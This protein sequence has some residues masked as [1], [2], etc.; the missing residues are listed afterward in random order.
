MAEIL[1]LEPQASKGSLRAGETGRDVK[2]AADVQ[3]ARA[4]TRR[5]CVEDMG[6]VEWLGLG[7]DLAVEK[8]D[9]V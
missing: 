8:M 1:A 4:A 5:S 2:K 7:S 9:L 3:R 6:K